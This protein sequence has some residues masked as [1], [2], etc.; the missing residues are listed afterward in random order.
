MKTYMI[1]A[2]RD[3]SW[4]RKEGRPGGKRLRAGEEQGGDGGGG[5]HGREGLKV[6][7]RGRKTQVHSLMNSSEVPGGQT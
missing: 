7:R 4:G 6:G 3:V 2:R 1:M 5:V